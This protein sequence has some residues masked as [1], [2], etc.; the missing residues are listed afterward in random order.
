MYNGILPV[1]KERGLTSHDVVFKL[2]KIL[3]MKKIGHTG[4][5]DPEVNGVL[6]ICLGHATR[7]SD[8]VMDM[9]KTYKATVT[10]GM[11]TTTEDQTGDI[12]ET[13]RIKA[14]DVSEQDID[15]TLE[16]FLGLIKQ[17][18]PMY[19]SVKV[20]GKKLYEY[21]RNNE[22]VERPIR[23]VYIKSI[24]RISEL[25]FEGEQ[26]HFDIEVTCGKGTYIRTLATDIGA[27]LA[28]PAHMS[29]LTR[30]ASGGFNQEASLTLDQIKVLHEHDSL[31]EKLFPIEYGLKGLQ[32]IEVSDDEFK[33][34]ILNG[35]KF[36]S[37]EFQY[38]FEE[39]FVFIDNHTN[40]ALAIYMI[41]PEKAH[42]IKPKK[43]FN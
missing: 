10:L 24:Q 23:H 31:Q 26:C 9:G 29:L 38:E 4:T 43:V 1:F 6:P 18:P 36:N 13:K 34:R 22:E 11:S 16:Q 12:L 2:R 28:F 21:A 40:K 20:K 41:H 17:I 8:Y 7:V 39:Q 35:Q 33:K 14:E 5:L 3:K 42:E 27:S 19:S 15:H 25:T 32:H 30:I 37:H